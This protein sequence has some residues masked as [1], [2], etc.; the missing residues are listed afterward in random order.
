M[1]PATSEL[2][3]PREI[4]PVS[5]QQRLGPD[6]EVCPVFGKNADGALTSFTDKASSFVGPLA[7]SL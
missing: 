2:L 6:L 1:A 3:F 4:I 5:I 7:R